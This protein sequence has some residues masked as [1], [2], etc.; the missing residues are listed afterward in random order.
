MKRHHC[1]YCGEDLGEWDRFSDRLDDCGAPECA[2]D[3]RNAALQEREE[4]HEQLDAAD[5]IAYRLENRHD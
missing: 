2:R 5:I 4:A 3:A 1:F